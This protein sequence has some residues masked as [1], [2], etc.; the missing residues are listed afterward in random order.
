MTPTNY[1]EVNTLAVPF[2]SLPLDVPHVVRILTPFRDGRPRPG[3]TMEPGTVA[4]V[5][6]I[7]RGEEDMETACKYEMGFP[8]VAHMNIEKGYKD[9]KYVNKLFKIIKHKK[10][11][12]GKAS[13]MTVSEVKIK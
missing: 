6:L 7:A 1:E 13:P 12:G 10:T 4:T 9:G 8:A 5:E 11:G 2:L 3:S